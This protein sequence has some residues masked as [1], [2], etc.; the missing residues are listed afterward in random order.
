MRKYLFIALFTVI[1]LTP[2]IVLAAPGDFGLA[3]ITRVATGTNFYKADASLGS[4]IGSIVSGILALAGT[5][6]LVLTIYAG[7]TWMTAAGNSDKIEKAKSILITA[8][9]GGAITASAYAITYFV[10][11][12][13]STSGASGD[14]TIG[15]CTWKAEDKSE[16]ETDSMTQSECQTVGGQWVKS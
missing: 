5:I 16:P 1:T 15:Q 2:F 10:M 13:L 12:K 3:K 8:V 9:I 14:N 6:F 4:T 11:G 7:I